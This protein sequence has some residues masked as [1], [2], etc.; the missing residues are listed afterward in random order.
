MVEVDL[1]LQECLLPS[2]R[3]VVAAL[4]ATLTTTFA[5]TALTAGLVATTLAATTTRTVATAAIGGERGI[6]NCGDSAPARA[7][8]P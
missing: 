3:A 8:L 1:D 6:K 4:T 2:R 7:P 5:S